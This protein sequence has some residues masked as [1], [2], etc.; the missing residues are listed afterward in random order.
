MQKMDTGLTVQSFFLLF[1]SDT[2]SV[3]TSVEY[4]ATPLVS[5]RV[6]NLSVLNALFVPYFIIYIPDKLIIDLQNCFL[7]QFLHQ[8]P[9]HTESKMSAALWTSVSSLV[10]NPASKLRLLAL[11]MPMPAPVRFAE[12]TYTVALSNTILRRSCS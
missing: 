11:F 7:P 9:C 3:V 2:F 12:P 4:S 10:S 5:V 1:S 6:F 8:L